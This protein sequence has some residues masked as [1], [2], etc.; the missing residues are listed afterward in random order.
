MA[1]LTR[2]PGDASALAASAQEQE[3]F[4]AMILKTA[5]Q[6]DTVVDDTVTIGESV[7]AIRGKAAVVAGAI[8]TAQPRYRETA[9]AL[10]DY[11]VS[12]QDAQDRADAAITAAAHS[13]DELAPLRQKKWS[14]DQELSDSLYSPID[15]DEMHQLIRDINTVSGKIHEEEGS[16][17]NAVAA[18]NA[19]VH[20]RDRAAQAAINRITPVLDELN[21]SLLQRVGAALDD[22]GGFLAAVTEWIAHVLTTVLI[23]IIL[24]AVA[25]VAVVIVLSLVFSIVGFVL[26][27]LLLTGVIHLADLQGLLNVLVTSLLVLIPILVPAIYLIMER[28]N[29]SPTPKMKEITL[30]VV[31]QEHHRRSVDGRVVGPYE[32]AF[33]TNDSIDNRGGADQTVVSIIQVMNSD[34]TPRLDA[35]GKPMWRVTLPSTQDWQFPLG[36][37][38]AMNDLGSNLSLIMTPNQQAAYERAVIAAMHQAGIG[39]NDPVML[40]GFSQGG[41]LAGRL[42]STDPQPFN[43]NAIAVAGAPIDAM[44]I[45]ANVSVLS[46]QHPDDPVHQLDG[47]SHT[48]T[49]NWVTIHAAKDPGEAFHGASSYGLTAGHAIDAAGAD[50]A[51]SAIAAEQSVFFSDN[52]VEHLYAGHE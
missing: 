28:E 42:A 41:I 12:L 27:L 35:N 45:P 29:L 3:R 37:T 5:R 31:G 16:F 18:Y 22:I 1:T 23:D 38:G 48:D 36:S 43:I 15:P 44:P 24:I 11:A 2:L 21:D 14:L 17:S 39:P 8:V 4:A 47:A 50:P 25:L 9:L 13:E 51:V 34:G 46:L 20:D 26:G 30:P 19:A 40:V 33:L 32:D 49:P 7:D 52:E 10:R 6:L